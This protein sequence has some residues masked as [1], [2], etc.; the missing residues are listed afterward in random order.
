M[1]GCYVSEVIYPVYVPV[2]IYNAHAVFVKVLKFFFLLDV[3]ELK[4]N[5]QTLN[6]NVPWNNNSWI[7][8][9][10][11]IFIAEKHTM[12]MQEE[13]LNYIYSIFA[14]THIILLIKYYCTFFWLLSWFYLIFSLF[15]WIKNL[16]TFHNCEKKCTI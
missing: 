3:S 2:Y 8:T 9:K 13:S 16:N 7:E 10:M 14:C 11:N 1:V 12:N 6:W 4:C 5:L 15:L